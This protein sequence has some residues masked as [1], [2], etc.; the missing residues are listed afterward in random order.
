ML[1]QS[2]VVPYLLHRRLLDSAAV[3]DCDVVVRDVSARN[4]SYTVERRRGPSYLLKQGVGPETRATVAHEA[5]VYATLWRDGGPTRRY[6]PRVY[7]FDE[8]VL[9][10]ELVGDGRDLRDHHFRRG[11]FPTTLAAAMGRVLGVL[12]ETTKREGRGGSGAGRAPWVLALHRPGLE[13]FRDLSSASLELVRILQA[14]PEYGHAVDGLRESW[15]VEALLHN[16]VKWDN[17]VLVP[18]GSDGRARRLKLVDWEAAGH[19]DPCWD[20]GSV[21]SHYLSSWV[22]SIPVTG[23]TLPERFPEL[24]QFPLEGMQ[25]AIGACWGAY[26]AARRLD[27]E[28]AD[29]CLQRAV[30][31][32]AARLVQT[33]FEITQASMMVTGNVVLHLQLALN[34]LLRPREAGAHLLGLTAGEAG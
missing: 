16:D 17:F 10:L 30:A 25:P 32:A 18:S 3:V 23:E 26:V 29:R 33:A 24:A 1:S 12:H 8:G 19:G 34:L 31:M 14:Q 22:L 4:S 28:E 21:F 7:G 5:A 27:P 9:V 11:R 15:R 13:V 6:L 20:I 2:D